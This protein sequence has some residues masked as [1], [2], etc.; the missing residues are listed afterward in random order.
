MPD[1]VTIISSCE[2]RKK[3]IHSKNYEPM[4]KRLVHSI[5]TNGGKYKDSPIIMWHSE[6]AS[7]S[8]ETIKW[9]E[10][11]GCDVV[12]GQPLGHNCEP[13]GNKI[14]AV[15][16]PIDT[17]FGLWIDTDM[18]LLD[19][20]RFEELLD[21]DFDLSA[22]GQNNVTHRWA[23]PE[24]DR[25]W[26]QFYELAGVEAPEDE[27][28]SYLDGL[29]SQVYFNSCFVLYRTGRDFPET[30]RDLAIKVRNSGV[31]GCEHNFT[32]TSLT[33][34][35]LKTSSSRRQLPFTYNAV[36]CRVGKRALEETLIHYQ[37]SVIDFD[38]RV[39]WDV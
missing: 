26:A 11:R 31:D 27:F 10:S 36:Y 23:G 30:W 20:V 22:P 18:Y 25:H 24:Y 35:A 16:T 14:M 4:A 17:E 3:D 7:P 6:G 13:V 2:F 32:Q 12:S 5:R 21:N 33:L 39:E 29:P 9:L 37:D 34:A 15:N 8:P 38:P 28:I 1:K 19:P